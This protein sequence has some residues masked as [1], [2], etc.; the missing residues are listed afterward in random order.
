MFDR[1]QVGPAYDDT[2]NGYSD[3]TSKELYLQEHYLPIANSGGV[4][5]VQSREELVKAVRE[6]LEHPEKL[7]EGRRRLIR[8]ICTFDDGKATD[9]GSKGLPPVVWIGA[10]IVIAAAV[11]WWVTR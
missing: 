3:Q 5:I 7:A 2:P 4:A 8:E 6:G 10:L 11:V 9:S 1:P